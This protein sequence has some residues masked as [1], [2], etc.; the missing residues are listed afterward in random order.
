MLIREKANSAAEPIDNSFYSADSKFGSGSKLGTNNFVVLASNKNT[1]D[2]T[3]LKEGTEYEIT[4]YEYSANSKK[5]VINYLT[6]TFATGSFKT[7]K[8]Q[9]INP[10]SISTKTQTDPPFTVNATATS[11]LSVISELVS[12]GVTVTNNI[13]T[14]VNPGPAKIK[15]SQPGNAEFAPAPELE[16]TFCVNPVTPAI[17]Y[18]AAMNGKYTLTSS[19]ASNNIWLKNNIAITGGTNQTIEVTPDASYT[20]KVD[21]SGCSSTSLPVANQ[22]INFSAISAKEEGQPDFALTATTTSSLPVSYEVVSGGISI[23]SSTVKINTP[24]PAKIKAIQSGNTSFF[25]ATAVEQ[26]FCVNPKVPT[27]TVTNVGPGEITLTSSSDTNNNWLRNGVA[28]NGAA[29]KTFKPELDGVYA[30]KVDYSGC[31]NTSAPTANLITAIEELINSVSL[32]P[33][34]SNGNLVIEW[35]HQNIRIHKITLLDAKGKNHEM[36]YEKNDNYI[37]VNLID[38]P[39]G[40]YVLSVH[41]EN[42][43][44]PIKVIKN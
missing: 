34:P 6:S 2:V 39:A 43:V 29:N 7:K 24:G 25:P 12:G 23:T 11:G 26:T 41:S 17:V 30:V 1:I 15:L 20:V 31:S 35:P 19:S 5:T 27:V 38:S 21:Y 16:V 42:G 3:N 9:T 8:S 4:A 10:I 36:N 40:V 37:Y 13:V 14:I 33:N 32:Y 44:M 22:T 18:A 28:I